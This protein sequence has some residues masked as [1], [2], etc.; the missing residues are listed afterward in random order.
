MEK[1]E[2]QSEIKRERLL[3]NVR[4]EE[5]K[6]T[7]ERERDERG[8]ER[9]EVADRACAA[10]VELRSQ[11]L[12]HGRNR[13]VDRFPSLDRVPPP[14]TTISLFLP[15]VSEPTRRGSGVVE[16]F[17]EGGRGNDRR[18][19]RGRNGR[20]SLAHSV[21]CN[22]ERALRE[23]LLSLS[24]SFSPSLFLTWE[25][26]PGV[27]EICAAGERTENMDN[28]KE[29]AGGEGRT[30]KRMYVSR[31]YGHAYVYVEE[32]SIRSERRGGKDCF[33]LSQQYNQSAI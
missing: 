6:R 1:D 28:L 27:T 30:R 3:N 2:R 5:R 33:F 29:R 17:D 25:I 9:K 14:P 32:C 13:R 8:S 15:N 19:G 11:V 4:K 16:A 12:V 24:F 21:L 10:T 7:K 20:G 18:K 31:V 23:R 26:L 22:V